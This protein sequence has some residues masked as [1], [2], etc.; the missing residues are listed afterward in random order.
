MSSVDEFHTKKNA[1][2]WPIVMLRVYTGVFFAYHGFR[3]IV[4]GVFLFV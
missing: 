2:L 4:G 1:H 3:K